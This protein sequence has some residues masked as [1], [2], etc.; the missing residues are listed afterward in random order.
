MKTLKCHSLELASGAQFNKHPII[1][2]K[3]RVS[4]ANLIYAVRIQCASASVIFSNVFLMYFIC[5]FKSSLNLLLKTH[6]FLLSHREWSNSCGPG[7]IL[8]TQE[9]EGGH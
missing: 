2:V 5:I 3:K 6:I 1:L 9:G 7:S 4:I 8:Q